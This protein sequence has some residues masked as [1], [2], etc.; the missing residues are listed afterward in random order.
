MQDHK[1]VVL[2]IIHSWLIGTIDGMKFEAKVCDNR[3]EF[4]IDEGR[5]IKLV[6]YRNKPDKAIAV[7]ERGWAK[8]P[9][10]EDEEILDSLL[11]YCTKLPAAHEWLLVEGK[12]IK[13][14]GELK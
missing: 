12:V 7:Y 11:E 9:K 4:G 2:R 5:V 13:A 3:S 8:Y 10:P 1:I 14:K 6:I